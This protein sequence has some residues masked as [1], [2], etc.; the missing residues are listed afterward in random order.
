M[1][2]PQD[3]ILIML[4][5]KKIWEDNEENKIFYNELINYY[6]NHIHNNIKSFLSNYENENNKIVI[7][8]FTKIIESIKDEY[9]YS[10]S[11]K[12]LG[13]IKKIILNK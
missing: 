13:V 6:N 7:Y 11:I 5:N 3:I 9:L 1:I 8:T 10:Y 12:N 4:L 2:L